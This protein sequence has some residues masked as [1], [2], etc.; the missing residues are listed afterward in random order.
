TSNTILNTG[1]VTSYNIANSQGGKADYGYTNNESENILGLARSRETMQQLGAELL[2][3]ALMLNKPN[4]DT[5]TAPS[6]YELKKKIPDQIR[7]LVVVP[8]N[9]NATL[10]NVIQ[11]REKRDDN[12]I[13]ELLEGGDDLFGYEHLNT[14]SVKREA[15]TDMIKIA[16]ST[17][18]PAVCKNTLIKHTRIFIA[19]HRAIKE[20]QTMSVLDFFEKSTA[21]SADSLNAK[22]EE[23]LFYMESNNIINHEEQTRFMALKKEDLDETYFDELSNL[24]SADSSRRTIE[25]RLEKKV[26]LAFINQSL[27]GQQKELSEISSKITNLEIGSITD[28][29]MSPAAIQ[30]IKRL[31]A[32]QSALMQE[33]RKSADANYANSRTP[34][35]IETRTLLQKWIDE[36]LKVESTLARLQVLKKRRNDFNKSYEQFAPLV[37]KIKRVEREIEIAEK[38]FLQNLQSLN[39]ARMHKESLLMSSQL[40][41]MDP[42]FYPSKAGASK[43][44][45][46]VALSFIV[47][48]VLVLA[49]A[50]TK[51]FMDNSLRDPERAGKTTNLRL[52]AGYPILPKNWRNYKRLDYLFLVRR[53]SE[54]LLQRVDLDLRQQGLKSDVPR[55]A[56]LSTRAMEGKSTLIELL[57]ELPNGSAIEWIEVPALL[58]GSYPVAKLAEMDVAL[59]VAD[60]TRTWNAADSRALAMAQEI[61]GHSCRLVI[62]KVKPDN[63]ESA[64]G[65]IPKKRNRI[66]RWIKRLAALNLSK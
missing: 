50:I 31:K 66:R 9:F 6:F 23:L 16:Y 45:T 54:Q 30:E 41:V 7:A 5:L 64:L 24:A 60:A 21:A 44:S 43:R 4:E 35:G 3:E 34:D 56:V 28:S 22:E 55:I 12:P 47:G 20:G 59:L 32:Q 63:L 49:L 17:S 52:A 10:Q 29:V 26:D 11:W 2:A 62:N 19:A 38:T 25:D 61:I 37:S 40:R 42:P 57:K 36:W 15:S 8:G 53:A 27:I 1:L 33:V 14:I 51:E 58:S 46:T 18:D 13:R 65:E 48:M 39:Q